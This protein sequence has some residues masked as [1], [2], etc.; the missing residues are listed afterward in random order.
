MERQQHEP[1]LLLD[2]ARIHQILD[3]ADL[4]SNLRTKDLKN[5]VVLILDKLV[6]L[7]CDHILNVLK[8]SLRILKGGKNPDATCCASSMVPVKHCQNK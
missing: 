6:S 4:I 8:V 1:E 3:F 2:R 7:A 5:T